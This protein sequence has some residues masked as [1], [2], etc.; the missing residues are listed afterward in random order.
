MEGYPNA[1]VCEEVKST[2]RVSV[3]RSIRR[4]A[5]L[6]MSTSYRIIEN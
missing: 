4:N 2:D 6:C 1:S 5:A 3:Q